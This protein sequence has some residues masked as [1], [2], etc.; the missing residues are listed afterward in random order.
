MT[1]SDKVSVVQETVALFAVSPETVIPEID[2]PTG[3]VPSGR[4]G[5]SPGVGDSGGAS[6]LPNVV[7]VASAEQ[8]RFEAESVEQT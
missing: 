6:P 2:G 1:E 7:K 4:V 3:S 8:A 5:A